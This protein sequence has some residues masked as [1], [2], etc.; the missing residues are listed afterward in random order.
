MQTIRIPNTDLSTSVLCMGSTGFGAEIDE[1]TAFAL[2][3]VYTEAGGNFIDTAKI[4][5]DWIPGETSRS[6]KIIGRWLKARASR[7][8]V[9][10]ASKGGHFHLQWPIVPR[11]SPQE[12]L[13]D[14]HESLRNLQ[15][16]QIDLYWLHRDDPQRPVE[17]ILGALH[18][19]QHSGLIGFY[20]ASNWTLERLL[21]AESAAKANGWDGF[22]AVQNMWNLAFLNEDGLEDPTIVAMD[23]P[24]WSYHYRNQF[25]AIPFSA[26]A[27]GLFQKLA[28][29]SEK[30]LPEGLHKMYGNKVNQQRLARIL[31]LQ[32]QSGL[33]ITQIVLGY[34]LS[35][36]FPTIPIF[37]ARTMEQLT[38][39]LSAA[40][41]RLTQEQ[42]EFLAPANERAA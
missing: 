39:T 15:T 35:Q 5:N 36:P 37:S 7:E 42:I 32:Q 4:Y 25:P 34:L 2:L 40:D 11:L 21:A 29:G 31:A 16:D 3:D 18:Q 24:L 26:Q 12:I 27:N 17:E 8:R 1:T 23:G 33:S 38:D 41:T 30:D 28:A 9:T 13:G 6:E 14:L 10:L 19:A 20:G 22:C